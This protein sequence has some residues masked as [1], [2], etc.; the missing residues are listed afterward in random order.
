MKNLIL[1]ISTVCLASCTSTGPISLSDSKIDRP[2]TSFA[3]T[4][5]GKQAGVLINSYSGDPGASPSILIRGIGSIN[6]S[7]EPLYILDGM[8]YNG[9]LSMINPNDIVSVEVLKNPSETSIYGIQGANG[10]IVIKTK[11]GGKR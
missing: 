11:K 6:A 3:Q 4:I 2:I 10:V 1:L 5:E 9:P 7:N 8:R